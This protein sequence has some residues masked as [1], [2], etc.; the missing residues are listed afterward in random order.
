MNQSNKN[1]LQIIHKKQTVIC[2]SL[3]VDTWSEARGILSACAPYICMVKVHCDLFAD[4]S[5]SCVTELFDMA[6]EYEF[7]IM[8]D[9]K[10][11]D[12]PK[13]VYKQ[14]TNPPFQIARW[15]DY[16]T[17]QPLNYL[18]VYEYLEGQVGNCTDFTIALVC[19]AEMNTQNSFSKNQEYLAMVHDFV[20]H[21]RKQI[22]AI[23]SQALFATCDLGKPTE[24]LRMTPGVC[25]EQSES[26][27]RYRT[28]EDAICRD[29]NHVVIIGESLINKHKKLITE[30]IEHAKYMQD[31]ARHSYS[32]FA[33]AH[34]L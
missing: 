13:I 1:L 30:P 19:V 32:C 10:F 28:I 33:S 24:C 26:G 11:S 29:G 14:L 20:I 8:Q 12:V 23:V 7:L 16:V 3:D 27:A 31:L 9:S 2:L 5:Q 6:Q 34:G 25:I 4:W 22:P 15:A 17:I 18:D 21:N